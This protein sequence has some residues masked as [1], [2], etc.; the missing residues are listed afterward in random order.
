MSDL[1]AL[2]AI[3][4]EVS[5]YIILVGFLGFI[6]SLIVYGTCIEHKTVWTISGAVMGVTATITI[7][8]AVLFLGA[9]GIALIMLAN[10][11]LN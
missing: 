2:L 8:G 4:S 7:F 6:I 10:A 1:P 3:A 11:S 9:N 5:Q